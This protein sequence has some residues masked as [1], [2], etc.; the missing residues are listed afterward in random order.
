MSEDRFLSALKES[1]LLKESEK[2]FND[3]KP[4]TN[5]SQERIEKIRKEFD[6]SRHKF[7]KS[8]INEIRKIFT[9]SRMDKNLFESKIKDIE[10]N[11]TE[12][13]ENL[14]K[15]KKYYDYDDTG[16]KGIKNEKDLFDLVTD[17]YYYKPIK[18]S[19]LLIMTTFKVKL[20]EI[21]KKIYR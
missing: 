15:T 10:R 14:F 13:K 3:T 1:E 11:L 12:L 19:V 7:S 2:N 6:E 4:K 20:K 21:K 5:F 17:K 8:E 9:K 16:Y 18:K